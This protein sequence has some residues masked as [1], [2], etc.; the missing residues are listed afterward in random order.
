MKEKRDSMIFYRSFYEAIK[1][2]SK[3]QQGEIYNAIFSYGLDFLEPELKGISKTIWTLIK[4]QIDANIKRYNNGK[5][6]KTKQTK[7]ETEAKDKQ[8]VSETEANVNVNVNVN[9]NN[10][11]NLNVKSINNIEDRKLKFAET[12]KIYLNLYGKEMMNEFFKYWTEPNTTNTKLKFEL[13]KTWSVKLRLDRW[14]KNNNN[15]KN[16]N[17]GN[18]QQTADER[19][20]EAKSRI[21]GE[22]SESSESK[23]NNEDIEFTSFENVGNF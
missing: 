8:K 15:F 1:E 21:L 20:Q 12:L 19:L 16:G 4:P 14:A 23:P 11:S 6:E 13:Q 9:K 7:S 3:E 2:L 10:N 18:K 17:N 22:D 5:V